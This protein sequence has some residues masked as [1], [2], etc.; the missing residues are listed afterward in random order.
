MRIF[1]LLTFAAVFS[2]S[3]VFTAPVNAAVSPVSEQSCHF[4]PV[5]DSAASLQHTQS[6][7]VLYSENTLSNLQYL[8]KYH[9]VALRS[10]SNGA[11]DARIRNAFINS[12]DP[13]LAT[14][15]LVGSLKKEFASVTV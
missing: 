8:N 13:Q 2:T 14:D 6:V 15:W 5:V 7:G 11:L 9:S 12:S 1:N 4:M 3:I 10:G